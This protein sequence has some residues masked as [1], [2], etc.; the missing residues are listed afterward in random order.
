MISVII[1]TLNE[2][3]SLPLSIASIRKNTVNCEILVID[4]GSSDRTQER[5]Q[6]LGANLIVS[7]IRQRATQL[8]LGTHHACG[9]NFLFLHADTVVPQTALIQI[10]SAL[11]AE[12]VGGGAF[13][14]RFNSGS[15]FLRFTCALAEIRNRAI[16]WHLG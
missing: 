10:E 9:D 11:K 4:C 6:E 13:A 15:L 3:E 12:S 1:P 14:R 2:E 16:G 7:S 8:N 5:A